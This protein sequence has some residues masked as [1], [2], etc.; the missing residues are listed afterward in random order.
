MFV[1]RSHSH[2]QRIRN[3]LDA[4]PRVEHFLRSS[5][6]GFIAKGYRGGRVEMWLQ[7]HDWLRQVG[8]IPGDEEP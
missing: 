6:E 8:L 1:L 5:N 2:E 7:R 4:L 3:F